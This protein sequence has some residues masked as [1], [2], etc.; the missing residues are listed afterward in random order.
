MRVLGR[1]GRRP[2]HPGVER[3]GFTV[4]DIGGRRS[5]LGWGSTF[6]GHSTRN[7]S[8][9][10]P[11]R[12]AAAATDLCART[13]WDGLEL[14]GPGAERFV[15]APQ[16]SRRLRRSGCRSAGAGRLRLGRLPAVAQSLR[17]AASGGGGE[18]RLGAGGPGGCGRGKRRAVPTGRG[19]AIE[20]RAGRR[21]P[22]NGQQT[23]HD[24]GAGGCGSCECRLVAGRPGGCGRPR[25]RRRDGP[26]RH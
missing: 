1:L 10:A 15:G 6:P 5:I 26:G 8:L 14:A 12:G 20:R 16:K 17:G 21:K 13:G 3:R 11:A 9:V 7:A 19:V 18:R 24:N 4:A 22:T 23:A 25:G 2:P